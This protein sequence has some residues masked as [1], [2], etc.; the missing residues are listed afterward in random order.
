MRRST[1]LQG[2]L[3]NALVDAATA[4]IAEKGVDA[5]SVSELTRRLGVSS[6][7]PYRHFPS[8][9][10]LLAATAAQTARELAVEMS[11]AV[12]EV[13]RRT[14]DDVSAAEALAATAVAYATF[15]AQR[16][17]G[18]EFIFA[19]ELTR[20]NCDE[21]AEAGR[22]VID[23]LLPLTMAIAQDPDEAL[24]LMEHHIA[25]AHGLGALSR[26]VFAHRGSDDLAAL[27]LE[28]ARVTHT[29]VS[30]AQGR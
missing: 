7:A 20:L 13:R 27:G 11:A 28:A 15:V 30:A 26:G 1:H 8:R 22:A 10:D 2:N 9:Q 6:G 24:R 17:A 4:L 12:Q 5:L 18:F 23:V 3:R 14:G 21:L 16:R 19:D 25:A 29:L